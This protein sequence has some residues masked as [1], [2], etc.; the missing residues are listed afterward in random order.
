ME[1]TTLP[2]GLRILLEEEEHA[3]TASVGM[4]IGA[5]SRMEAPEQSGISHFVEHILFKGTATYS[6]FDIAEA[7]DSI[8]AQFNAYTT[9][10]YTCFYLRVLDIHLEKAVDVLFDML[11]QSKLDTNDIEL[12]KGVII[13]EIG[14]YED[15]PEDL[16]A[17]SLYNIVWPENMLG[18]PILGS[19]ETVQAVTVGSLKAY[20]QQY[21]TPERMVFSASGKFERSMLL[22]KLEQYFGALVNQGSPLTAQAA[23]YKGGVSRINRDFEQINLCVA[24]PSI[25]LHE[26]RRY[27]LS[28]LNHV[29]GASSSSRLFQRIREELGLAYSVGSSCASF[30]HEGIFVVDMGVS[31]EQEE[32]AL[33]E[34][35]LVL[36]EIKQNGLTQREFERVRRQITAGTIMSS[37][38]WMSRA[39]HNGRSE[40]LE[41]RVLTYEELVECINRVTLEE[42]NSL[43][44][45]LFDFEQASVVAVGKDTHD[46]EFYRGILNA[47]SNRAI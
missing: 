9:K 19:R 22:A 28:I 13:E 2:N 1:K 10:E 25:A 30:L 36:Q 35:C 40:L 16:M 17:D 27:A 39:S 26:S 38:S 15:S 18:K 14:M 6:A 21:Y 47:Y 44:A 46:E 23:G 45:E 37:E 5:G 32:A 42:V 41:N 4:W 31:L 43:A 12:E 7:M 11:T 24:F 8:G 29:V 20:M 34:L 33:R 3:K